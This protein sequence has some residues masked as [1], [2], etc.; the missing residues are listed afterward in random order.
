MYNSVFVD[1]M[2]NEVKVNFPPKRIIS[3][4]PSQTE[5]LFYLGLDP[6]VV[7]ITKF[8]NYP[9]NKVD[10]KVKVGGT[11]QLDLEQIRAL[12]PDLI[13]ANKEE[14]DKLQVETL[15]EEFPVWVS[16]VNDL[17]TA[18][19]M[20][21]SVGLLVDRETEASEVAL[22]IETYF[23]LLEVEA[24]NLRVAYLIWK[25]PFKVAGKGTFINDMLLHCGFANAFNMERYP[26]VSIEHLKEVNPDVVML[27]SEPYPF[28]DKHID[29][30]RELLPNAQIELVDGE[31][32]SWYGSHLLQAPAYFK[33][34][35]EGL[36]GTQPLI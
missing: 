30:I 9:A 31:M 33:N 35:Y 10:S 6:E 5:L 11:K 17:P 27:S 32:F 22:Q 15:A 13:I 21:R 34:L 12:N 29:E 20:I 24:N 36:A 3:L 2:S 7:G 16:D 8:C 19:Q 26:T 4:V 1:Q 28:K 25:N 18:L 23:S 14:N